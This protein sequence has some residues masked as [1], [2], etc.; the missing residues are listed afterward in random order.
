M[1]SSAPHDFHDLSERRSWALHAE[2][3]ARLTPELVERARA[4][5]RAWL[6]HDPSAHPYAAQWND[7]LLQ[8]FE[9][10]RRALVRRDD[11]MNTLRQASPFA[12]AI[13][14]KTR[15]KILKQPNLRSRATQ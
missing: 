8:D 1:M 6:T 14:A 13:D 7:V 4:R 5:V 11:E 12:G 2:V 9:D 15:W 10:I 3:A